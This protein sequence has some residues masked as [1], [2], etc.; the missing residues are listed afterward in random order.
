MGH[1]VDG[2]QVTGARLF[3]DDCMEVSSSVVLTGG[4]LATLFY[5]REVGG[6]YFLPQVELPGSF[7]DQGTAKPGGPGGEYTV[8]HVDSQGGADDQVNLVPD[9]HQVARLL[10]W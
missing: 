9:P 8:E 6:K 2:D 1:I 7:K 5:R 4:T 10:L 3:G